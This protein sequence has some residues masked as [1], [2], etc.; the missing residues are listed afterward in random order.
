MA[1]RGVRHLLAAALAAMTVRPTIQAQAPSP[2]LQPV[3]TMKQLMS[4][5]IYPASNGILVAVNRGGPTDDAE[6]A[7]V[8]RGAMTLAES[9]NLLV[10][11]NGAPAWIADARTLTDMGL[12]AYRAAEAR[13]VKALAATIDRVDA[14]CTMCHKHFRTALFPPGR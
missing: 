14:S 4:D 13:D 5:V 12:A 10:M 6:W 2:A 8:R 3:A 11:R 7:E 9:G 1:R